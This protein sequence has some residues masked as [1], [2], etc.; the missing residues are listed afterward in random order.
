MME[1][2]K[3]IIE[4]YTDHEQTILV[5]NLGGTFTFRE[6]N[7]EEIDSFL[8][9]AETPSLS[10]L[11]PLTITAENGAKALLSGEF[12]EEVELYNEDNEPYYKTVSVT[13]STIKNIY[14]KI[15]EHYTTAK[16]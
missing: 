8:I 11:L 14:R 10:C 6:E 2:K 16:Q 5:N 3:Y 12:S 4:V 9:G 13:W 1:T 7:Q 15:V